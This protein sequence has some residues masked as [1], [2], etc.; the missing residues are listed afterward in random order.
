MAAR[1]HLDEFQRLPA[2]ILT[3]GLLQVPLF[4][5]SRLTLSEKYTLPPIGA[6]AF[7][8]AVGNSTDTITLSALLVG[9]LRFLWKQQL[10]LLADFSKRGGAIGAFTGGKVSGLILVT[11]LVVR[12]NLQVS[13]LSFTV[14][15]QRLD[16]IEVS[17]GLQHVPL[18]GAAD[19]LL[20]SGV[21]AAMTMAEFLT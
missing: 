15:S 18:P 2:A 9:P 6:T 16:T 5:V 21:A 7:R 17:V 3:D 19:L 20:D 1:S 10:E 13:D 8:A 14:S 12:A 4:A 11:R